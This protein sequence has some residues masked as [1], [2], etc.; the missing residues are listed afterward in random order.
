MAQ[1]AGRHCNTKGL[2]EESEQHQIC[3]RSN[4]ISDD[5][6]ANDEDQVN[7]QLEWILLLPAMNE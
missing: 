2:W 5:P 1:K 7:E 3:T 6:S 4:S